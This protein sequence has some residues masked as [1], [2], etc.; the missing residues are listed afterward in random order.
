[1][2]G[3]HEP[4]ARSLAPITVDDLREWRGNP[5]HLA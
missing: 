2:T 1:M 3:Q 4:L 5:Q